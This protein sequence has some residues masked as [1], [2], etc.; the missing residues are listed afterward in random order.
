MPESE[1]LDDSIKGKLENTSKAFRKLFLMRFTLELIRHSRVEEFFALKKVLEKKAQKEKEEE[2]I[3]KKR[4]GKQKLIPSIMHREPFARR[5]LPKEAEPIFAKF[6][7]QPLP[8]APHLPAARPTP[9]PLKP[10][11]PLRIPEYPLP[12]NLQYIRPVPRNVEIDLGRLNPITQDPNVR[13]IECNGPEE[14]LI[15]RGNTGTR[16]TNIVLS[17]EEIDQILQTFSQVSKIPVHEGVVKI[18]VGRLILSAIISDV[19]GS[20][21]IIRKMAPQMLPPGPGF[22]PSSPSRMM[23]GPQSM[24]SSR[25]ISR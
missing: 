22:A 1:V 7:P 4:Y 24:P 10:R 11:G 18:V 19:V 2:K 23:P 15:V 13:S 14:N 8:Q 17:K 25:L 3:F 5:E 20:K 12:P 16:T 9:S 21:F 6:T